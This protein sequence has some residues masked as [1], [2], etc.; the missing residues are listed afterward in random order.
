MRAKRKLKQRAELSSDEKLFVIT[1]FCLP[2]LVGFELDSKQER[3]WWNEKGQVIMKFWQSDLNDSDW[4]EDPIYK[5]YGT[6][7]ATE[8][9]EHNPKFYEK[10]GL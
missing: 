8:R 5:G 1:G 10:Y 6:Q 2:F 9:K 3:D 4:F 7:T